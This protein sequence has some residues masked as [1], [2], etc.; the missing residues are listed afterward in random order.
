MELKYRRFNVFH[1]GSS[2]LLHPF[3]PG[4]KLEIVE[5]TYNL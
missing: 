3:F 2:K 4:L 1:I 5:D